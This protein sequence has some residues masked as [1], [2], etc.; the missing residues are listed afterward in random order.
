MNYKCYRKYNLTAAY[1][2]SKLKSP[3]TGEV[4]QK[5]RECFKGVIQCN[6]D[7][8]SE[9]CLRLVKNPM[10]ASPKGDSEHMYRVH[11]TWKPQRAKPVTSILHLYV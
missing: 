3:V 8:L 1:F 7:S 11:T 2:A 5:P 9:F 6:W 10:R 4:L